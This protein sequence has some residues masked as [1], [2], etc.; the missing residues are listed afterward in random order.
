MQTQ[1]DDDL[2]SIQQARDLAVA[3]RNAQREFIKFEQHQVDRI[4]EA[5]AT[6]VC[7]DAKRLGQMAHDETGYG[8]A[9]HKR[10]KIEFSSRDVWESIR[11]SPTVG[12]LTRD[13]ARRTVD[14]GRPVG[15]VEGL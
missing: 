12:E 2:Q 15:V 4:C 13:D 14:V 9:D 7:S 8:N 11:D 5:M 3:A 6:A 1:F 10:I